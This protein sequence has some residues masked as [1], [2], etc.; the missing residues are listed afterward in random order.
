MCLASFP[1]RFFVFVCVC[2]RADLLHVDFNTIVSYAACSPLIVHALRSVTGNTPT[3]GV[4][5][6]IPSLLFPPHLRSACV[7]VNVAVRGNIEKGKGKEQL[8]ITSK[9]RHEQQS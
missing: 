2:L 7:F 9:K 1:L 4:E 3:T 8:N 5:I 6:T